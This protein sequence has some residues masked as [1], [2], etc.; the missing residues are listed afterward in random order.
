MASKAE[1]LRDSICKR[2]K[3]EDDPD[4]AKARQLIIDV[5]NL[6]SYAKAE[7]AK[8]ADNDQG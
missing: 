1:K 3:I 8:E 6:L 4:D 5:W 2:L 7:G